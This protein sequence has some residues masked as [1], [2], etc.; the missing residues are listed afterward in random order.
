MNS[1]QLPH[2]CDSLVRVWASACVCAIVRSHVLRLCG[3]PIMGSQF[4]IK[5]SAPSVVC[6]TSSSMQPRTYVGAASTCS[7]NRPD[8]DTFMESTAQLWCVSV[9]NNILFFKLFSEFKNMTHIL[10]FAT[11]KLST[12]VL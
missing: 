4:T 5:I 12:M 8:F 1:W 3:S 10:Y 2:I 6:T 11:N 9:H 7:L